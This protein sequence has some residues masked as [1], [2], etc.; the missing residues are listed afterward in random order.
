MPRGELEF[1]QGTDSN[2]RFP[3]KFNQELEWEP[4]G[5]GT[6]PQGSAACCKP[7]TAEASRIC[8]VVFTSSLGFVVQ[9]KD[10]S[11]KVF[12]RADKKL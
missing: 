9:R 10:Q 5:S 11:P 8:W 4:D 3:R 2:G 12:S 7:E 1:L 6:A